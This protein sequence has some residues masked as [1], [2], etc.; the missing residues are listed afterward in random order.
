MRFAGHLKGQDITELSDQSISRYRARKEEGVSGDAKDVS[1]IEDTRSRFSLAKELRQAV[2]GG[3]PVVF[4]DSGDL[5][6]YGP[7]VRALWEFHIGE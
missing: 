7:W 3:K 1:L 2:N 5:L 6:I 4:V